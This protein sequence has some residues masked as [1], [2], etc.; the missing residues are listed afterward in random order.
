MKI[1]VL[2]LRTYQGE[3]DCK[4]VTF[5]DAA[6]FSLSGSEVTLRMDIFAYEITNRMTCS[7]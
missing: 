7:S 1:T 5:F 6:N 4:R 2:R 3:I